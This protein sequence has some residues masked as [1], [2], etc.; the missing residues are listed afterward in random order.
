[1]RGWV[2]EGRPHDL[3]RKAPHAASARSLARAR[4]WFGGARMIRKVVLAGLASIGFALASAAAADGLPAPRFVIARPGSASDIIVDRSDAEVVRLAAGMLAGDIGAVSGSRPSLRDQIPAG[5]TPIIAGT[6]TSSP[7]LQALIRAKGIDVSGLAGQWEAYRVL[8]VTEPWPGVPKAL[9][10]IGADR[11]GTA[12]GLLS[13]SREIGVSPYIW[14]ADVAPRHRDTLAVSGTATGASPS[15]KYRGIFIND[16][17]W[18]LRPWA[19]HTYEPEKGNIGPKTYDRVF[20]LLLRLRA[21]ILWPA[22]HP[23]T[24]AFNQDARNAVEADRYAIVMGSSHAEPMLRNNVAEWDSS[25]FGAFDYSVNAGRTHEYWDYRVKA[26]GRFENMYTVGMR[27]IHDSG[28]VSAKGADPVKLLEEVIADQRDILAHRVNAEVAEVPQVFLPYKEVLDTYRKGLTLA[29]DVTLGWVDDNF[30][31]IRQLSTP[32]ERKRSGGAGVY[33]HVSYWGYPHDYL[34][35]AT[36]PLS[37]IRSEMGRAYDTGARRLWILNVGDIKPA[38]VDMEYFLDLAYD[39]AGVRSL[40]QRSYLRGWAER[41]FPGV[42]S[43]KLAD[44]LADSFQLGLIRKPEHMG[45]T[46]G[47]VGV[48]R[49]QFSPVAY[50]DEGEAR[51]QAYRDLAARAQALESGLAPDQRDAFFELVTYPVLAAARASEKVIEADR[52]YLYAW[53]G[54]ASAAAHA[55]RSARAQQE[56]V[57]ATRRFDAVA[58]GKWKRIVSEAPRDLAIFQGS[59]RGSASAN[60][61]PGLGIAVEG[62]VD[63]LAHAP[64][65][66]AAD[67]AA[68]VAIWRDPRASADSLP[69]FDRHLGTAHFIDVFNTG[70]G[71]IDWSASASTPWVRLAESSGRVEDEHRLWV[72]IDPRR[73]PRGVGDATISISSGSQSYTVKLRLAPDVGRIPPGAFIESGGAVSIEAEHFDGQSA[74]GWVLTDLGRTGSG[75][76]ETQAALASYAATTGAP[77]VH[78]TFL[79]T[80]PGAARA[81][82][83]ALP[84]FPLNGTRKLRY[85]VAIDGAPPQIVSMND[86]RWGQEVLQNARY[87]ETQWPVLK[88]GRHEL[89][90]WA[91]DPGLVIDKLV[92]DLGGL[93]ASYLGPPE[94][95]AA[96]SAMK[97]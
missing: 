94:T 40:D 51:L 26:N 72:R 91:L 57:A 85:A 28:A 20:E 87:T 79:T 21:N 43:A 4:P 42:D 6:L 59:P 19:S 89:R 25:H 97:R 14:W 34:W 93:R 52:S 86:D 60:V 18:G 12:Y 92:V 9:V 75:G 68:E 88:P 30:G 45:F 31:Y 58:G 62:S 47:D 76:I 32:E 35:L 70:G 5:G 33:Y 64:A 3:V 36:T 48:Q 78:Y 27:G 63:A 1:M 61:T 2:G 38:E 65:R 39:H 77:W 81:I 10:I 50:G 8:T 73:A 53:Q 15:V 29:D 24:V 66:A 96:T 16:E 83:T 82:V 56:I 23:G 17:D 46:A 13:L 49:T 71:S 67:Y 69:V 37:L 90:L 11:R 41:T 80:T 7:M 22:M 74:G 95:R 44:V 54:R 84:S 55:E